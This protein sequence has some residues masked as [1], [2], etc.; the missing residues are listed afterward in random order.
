MQYLCIDLGGSAAKLGLVEDGIIASSRT[1][2]INDTFSLATLDTAIRELIETTERPSRFAA[3]GIAVPGV[4]DT[5]N[6]TLLAAHGKY[7]QL[8]GVSLTTWATEMYTVPARI[9][10]DARAALLGEVQFGAA[11]G[12]RDV[13]LMVLGTGIGTAAMMSGDLLRGSRD[14][15]GILGGHV[16]V[17]L[18]GPECPCGNRGCAEALAS[19]WALDRALRSDPGYSHSVWATHSDRP[20]I[21]ALVVGAKAGDP[22]ATRVLDDF[23]AIW[24]ATLVSLCHAYDPSVAVV[25]GGV[26]KSHTL[27]L[28]G[29]TN[30]VREHLWRSSFRPPIVVAAEPELS[31]MRG[32]SAIAASALEKRTNA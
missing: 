5:T 28:P 17:S 11:T 16:T 29:I 22:V 7:R 27:I 10:N 2:A 20:D 15:A 14:H 26:M 24:G 12:H 30:Y 8:L 19:T 21:A 1:V 23:I 4:I 13:V 18:D 9:E 3:I 32:L 6:G 25:S 31:V